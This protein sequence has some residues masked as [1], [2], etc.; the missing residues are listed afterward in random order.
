MRKKFVF[1]GVVRPYI[2][3]IYNT[4]LESEDHVWHV[5]SINKKG[6]VPYSGIDIDAT[7]R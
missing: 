3:A 6:M 5:S 4:F 2:I 7:A 1:E